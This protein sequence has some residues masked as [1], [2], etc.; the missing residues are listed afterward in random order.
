[1]HVHQLCWVFWL[2]YSFMFFIIC[3]WHFILLMVLS[4]VLAY[5][6]I[7]LCLIFVGAFLR[8]GVS[9]FVL[10]LSVFVFSAVELLLCILVMVKHVPFA[11][12]CKLWM[13]FHVGSTSCIVLF[14]VRGWLFEGALLLAFFLMFVVNVTRGPRLTIKNPC[15]LAPQQTTRVFGATCTAFLLS[16][17]SGR[18]T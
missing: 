2:C 8:F 6:L 17:S 18:F 9:C 1:M 15:L 5:Q 7:N 10:F 3:C 13:S 11:S 14:R 12:F 4:L 16:V